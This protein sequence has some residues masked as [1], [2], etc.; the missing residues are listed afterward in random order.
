MRESAGV[1]DT[2]ETGDLVS[3]TLESDWFYIYAALS[4]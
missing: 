3:H 4:Y 2:L 1:C